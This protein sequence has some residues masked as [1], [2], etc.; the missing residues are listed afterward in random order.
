MDSLFRPDVGTWTP[1]SP[2]LATA[3]RGLGLVWIVV[4]WAAAA[5]GTGIPV[6]TTD[7]WPWWPLAA[8]TVVAVAAGVALW[9]WAGRNRRSWG[10]LEAESDLLVTRGVM[11]RRLV[12]IPYGRMQFVDVSAGP[13]ARRLGIATV[14]L[15]TASTETAADIPGVPAD[16]ARRL[17]NR[18]TEIGESHGAGL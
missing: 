14:T 2:R 10:Y 7:D 9:V 3:R 17:R 11:F 18:L 12:A 5:A 4:L 6:A 8:V 16:E 13:V 1:V 15:H